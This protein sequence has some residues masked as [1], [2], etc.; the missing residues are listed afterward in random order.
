ML[1]VTVLACVYVYFGLVVALTMEQW[2][3]LFIWP[4][5]FLE[6]MSW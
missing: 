2:R 3:Y 6:G 4:K 1:I 5:F